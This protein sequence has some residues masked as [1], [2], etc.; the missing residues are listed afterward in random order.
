ML[1]MFPSFFNHKWLVSKKSYDN[2]LKN[3]D[4]DFSMNNPPRSMLSKAIDIEI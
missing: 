3:K 1:Y 4:L 2:C